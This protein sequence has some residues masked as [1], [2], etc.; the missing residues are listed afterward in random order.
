[1]TRRV[2]RYETKRVEKTVSALTGAT[3]LYDVFVHSSVDDPYA[4]YRTLRRQYP[5]YHNPTRGF[6]AL[7]R[8]ED[9][10]SA[11]RSWR[12]FSN[13]GG[14]DIDLGPE[15]F[16]AGNFL[17]S[18][19]P[20]HDRLRDV[21]KDA[22]SPRRVRELEDSVHAEVD[23]LLDPILER[24]FGEFVAD[25]ASELPVR[26]IF[27]LMG[28]STADAS[29]IALLM[30]DMLIR[31]PGS[32]EVP[33]PVC[34]ALATLTDYFTSEAETRRRH[35]KDDLLSVIVDAEKARAVLDNEIAGLC[36]TLLPAGWA[37]SSILTANTMWLLAQYPD[38]RSL[39]AAEPA[40]VPAAIEEILRFES[41]AQQHMPTAV[42]DVE[43]HGSTIPAGARVLLLWGSANRDEARWL[44][45][46][47]FNIRRDVRRNCA[48]GEG[49]HHCLGAPLA[50]LEG[51]IV[52]EAV[53]RR[54]PNWD[55][56]DP[57]RLPGVI[58]RVI[59]RLPIFWS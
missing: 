54:N 7:S 59:S 2:P 8:W 51:R 44:D 52:L 58:L 29:E 35:P 3:G 5:V 30:E 19:P 55:T 48:F 49:I 31:D 12:T 13:A 39:L 56:G 37:T 15:F 45:A 53:L 26:I 6:W 17:D 28:I 46:D 24:G 32:S 22:F 40:R 21:V 20:K 25:L 11:A 42:S 14:A 47:I 50:R 27:K 33:Q 1:M 38:Q 4:I 23:K 43:L 34:Q 16:G 9:V 57:D 41:R 18:D 36:V 10:Q